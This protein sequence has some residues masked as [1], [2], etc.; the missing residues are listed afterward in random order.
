MQKAR[1][2]IKIQASF[3]SNTFSVYISPSGPPTRLQHHSMLSLPQENLYRVRTKTCVPAL[4]ASLLSSGRPFLCSPSYNIRV[5]CKESFCC[6]GGEVMFSWK[7]T[8]RE[9][10]APGYIKGKQT[11]STTSPRLLVKETSRNHSDGASGGDD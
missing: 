4:S 6:L 10:A 8:G 2:P 1:L 5:F 11:V 9:V 3:L 7:C